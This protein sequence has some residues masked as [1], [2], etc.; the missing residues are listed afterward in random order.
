MGTHGIRW[1]ISPGCIPLQLPAPCLQ[2]VT[3]T[4][5]TLQVGAGSDTLDPRNGMGA[6][7]GDGVLFTP[8]L[9]LQLRK[10]PGGRMSDTE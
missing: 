4:Q 5:V 2:P 6:L 7:E 10:E 3:G 8:E 9:I 1:G